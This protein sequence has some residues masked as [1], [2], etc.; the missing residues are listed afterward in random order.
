MRG[1][2]K[3]LIAGGGVAALEAAL[4]LRALA[5]DLVDVE[6]LAPE[7]H[8]WYRPMSVAEP[9]GLGEARRFDLAELAAAA[10]A[11]FTP[12]ALVGVDVTRKV[13]R[14]STGTVA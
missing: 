9:F 14:T 12:A 7:H 10:G 3:V 2:T 13:A 6:L 5:G 4:A 8:F 1:D 11:S